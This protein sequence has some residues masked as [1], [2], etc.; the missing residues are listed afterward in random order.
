D[1]STEPENYRYLGHRVDQSGVPTFRYVLKDILIEDRLTPTEKGLTRILK[2]LPQREHGPISLSF[3]AHSGI[4]LRRDGPR[5][6]DAN[7]LTVTVPPEVAD[8]SC[9]IDRDVGSEWHVPVQLKGTTEFEV[10]YEW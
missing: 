7:G 5:C 9:I 6:S 8:G 2:I 3:L 10:R 4:G 1:V